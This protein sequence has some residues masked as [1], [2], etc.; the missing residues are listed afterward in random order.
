MTAATM[1]VHAV[2][3]Q[4]GSFFNTVVYLTSQ[5]INLLVFFNFIIIVLVNAASLLIWIFFDQ[6]RSIESKVSLLLFNITPLI[7]HHGQ[8]LE[9][10]LPLPA[11][12]SNLEI[13]FRH[14]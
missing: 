5:K 9:E 11:T 14:L 8:V 7:V 6:I 1:V 10:D 4:D 3:K 2:Q 13:N 12:N